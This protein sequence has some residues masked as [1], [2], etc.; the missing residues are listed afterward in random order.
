MSASILSRRHFLETVVLSPA[1][2]WL[3]P[4]EALLRPT[5]PGAASAAFPAP[6]TAPADYT[7]HIKASSV[8]IAPKRIFS[9][10]TYNGQ[11]PGPLLRFK[12][13]SPTTVDVFNDTDTPEQ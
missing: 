1:G 2:L 13:G 3:S 4:T 9:T 8:E 7:L 5:V 10:V 12:E 11:F 6:Q